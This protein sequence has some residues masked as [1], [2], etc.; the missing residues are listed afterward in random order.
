V[1][2]VAAV[3]SAESLPGIA[4]P[5]LLTVVGF[6]SLKCPLTRLHSLQIN[7]PDYFIG[8][9]IVD[10]QSTMKRTLSGEKASESWQNC[11][12]HCCSIK[13]CSGVLVEY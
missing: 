9:L 5:Q 7:S 6:C 10:S 4:Q 1:T 11:Y 2:Q 13:F 12:G 8:G 3:V